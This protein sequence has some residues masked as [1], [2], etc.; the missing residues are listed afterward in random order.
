MGM[1]ATRRLGNAGKGGQKLD[2]QEIVG[3]QGQDLG[4]QATTG[5]KGE[6]AIAVR[7]WMVRAAKPISRGRSTGRAGRGAGGGSA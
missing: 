6:I 7:M 2:A 1:T 3:D 4:E 5:D